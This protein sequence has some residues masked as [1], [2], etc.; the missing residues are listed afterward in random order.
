MFEIYEIVNG[1]FAY[2]CASATECMGVKV[3]RS[4]TNAEVIN[5]DGETVYSTF[6]DRRKKWTK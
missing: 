1:C 3:A 4:Y 5:P 6:N 2:V